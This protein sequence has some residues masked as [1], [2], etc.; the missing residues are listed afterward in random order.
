MKQS[1][2]PFEIALQSLILEAFSIVLI[3]PSTSSIRLFLADLTTFV[4]SSSESSSASDTADAPFKNRDGFLAPPNAV[5]AGF[6]AH[7]SDISVIPH[8]QTECSGSQRCWLVINLHRRLNR[9]LNLNRRPSHHPNHR[10]N[11]S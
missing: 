1:N 5:A 4:F 2:I 6:Y 11:P 3:E 10:L 7:C 8:T 9:R